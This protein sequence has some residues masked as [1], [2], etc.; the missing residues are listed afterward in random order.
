[1]LGN[2][3]PGVGQIGGFHFTGLLMEE[4]LE[5]LVVAIQSSPDLKRS[6]R[7]GASDAEDNSKALRDFG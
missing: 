3:F 1:L 2:P 6:L 5:K 7:K 4:E